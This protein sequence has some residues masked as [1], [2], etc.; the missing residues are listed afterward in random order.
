MKKLLTAI[1]ILTLSFGILCACNAGSASSK[2]S[3]TPAETAS[4]Y[5]ERWNARDQAGLHDLLYYSDDVEFDS[6]EY[7]FVSV[8]VTVQN[9]DAQMD[10]EQIEFYKNEISDLL[11]TAIVSVKN[12]TIYTNTE[13]NEEEE[14][15]DYLDYYLV[16]T[17]S[18]PDWMIAYI[19]AGQ[20]G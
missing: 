16:S 5:T 11:D 6:D 17:K 14:F 3:R 2:S 20:A 7:T 12:V 9:P 15:V 4:L 18:H 13:T 10:S 19:A 1:L 8:S